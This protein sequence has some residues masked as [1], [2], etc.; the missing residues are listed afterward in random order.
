MTEQ[1]KNTPAYVSSV[2]RAG[3]VLGLCVALSGI[4]GLMIAPAA[5]TP[6]SG[7]GPRDVRTG[8]FQQGLDGY[9]G[10]ADTHIDSADWGTPPQYTVNYGWNEGLALSDDSTPLLRF[11]LSSIPPNSRVYSATLS[12]Y[13]TTETAGHARRVLL[14]EVY[15]DWDEGNQ[16]G[17]PMDAPG[18]HGATGDDAFA[19]YPGEGTNVPW[20]A[21][22]M[23][24]GVDYATD[25]AD[26]VDVDDVGWFDWDVTD[27]VRAWVRGERPNFGVVLRDGTGWEPGNPLLRRF[28]SSQGASDPGLRPVLTIQYDPDTPLADAGPDQENLHWSGTS[29]VLDGSG[30]HDRPGGDDDALAYAWRI[31]TPAYGSDLSGVIGEEEIIEFTPDVPGEWELELTVTNTLGAVATD[32][33][34]VRL[35]SIP[36]SHPR[37]YL[38]PEKLATLRAR[39]TP[40]NVRWTQLVAEAD[41][42]PTRMLH[43]ALVGVV[44]DDPSYRVR[45]IDAALD[46]IAAGADWATAVGKL[47]LVFDWCYDQLTPAERDTFVTFFNDSADSPDFGGVPGWGNYWPR[48]SFSVAAMALATLGDNP[49]AEQ[50]LDHFRYDRFRDH[51]VPAL[52][53]IAAGGGW[54]EGFIYDGIANESLVKALAAWR[55]ATG[56]NLFLASAWFPERFGHLLMRSWPGVAQEWGP[57]YHPYRAVGDSERRRGTMANYGRIMGLILIEQFPTHPLASQLQAY[58]ATPPDDNS[59]SFLYDEEFLWFDPDAP[60][61][62]PTLLTQHE[63]GVGTLIVRSGWPSGA[64]D[65]DTSATYATFQA[66]DYFSYHQHLD[67]NSFTLFKYGDLA[68]DSGVYSGAGLSYHDVNY[69]MRTIAHNTLVVY[70]PSEDFSDTRPYAVSNDG[71]QRS[72]EPASR[73]PQTVEYW[74]Q[75]AQQYDVAD[76]PRFEDTPSYTYALGDATKAYNNPTYNQAML[77]QGLPGNVAKVTRF[78]REFVYLRP[79]AGQSTNRDYLVL[80]DRVGVTDPSFSGENTKLLFHTLNE[81]AVNGTGVTVSP[82]ET[83]YG[84]ADL[85]TADNGEGR[86]FMKLLAPAAH[87]V[88]KLGVCGDKAFWVFGETYDWHWGGGEGPPCDLATDFE[89]VPYGE[90]RIELEPA[91]TDLDHNFLTVLYP[92]SSDTSSMPAT[93]LLEATG[94][95]GAHIAD[96]QLGRIV[97]FSASFDGAPPT[98]PIAYS[99]TPTAP[100]LHVLFDLPPAERYDL[101]AVPSGDRLD[102]MLTPSASGAYVASGMGVLS[103]VLSAGACPG[104]IDGDGQ[105]GLADLATLLA[106]FGTSAGQPGFD[107]AADLDGDGTV[108]LADLSQLLSA[109]GSICI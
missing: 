60:A 84:D 31:V 75:H 7:D 11:D 48:Y 57:P 105:V 9:A 67:Q 72:V 70:N 54:P 55:S 5:A 16:V 49:R 38:T 40:D 73:A 92:T 20:T 58:L 66:G 95:E 52:N 96:D 82:G 46:R 14:F 108:G 103:F 6:A 2:R 34:H 15:R 23:A 85:I 71:G 98:G 36:T 94:M 30:S 24:A 53:K 102:V 41:H 35:L 42:D 62:E 37:I 109:Y 68:L 99:Y 83:L 107:P 26:W 8:V 56:E 100:T 90:W 21:R 19:Y 12:L 76:M 25:P 89:N 78:Q 104:D 79:V 22:G 101:S 59:D 45:A 91:D 1:A 74:E 43:N 51:H 18:K 93:T 97:L 63:A 10:V 44:A 77:S 27:V 13:N 32:R 69:Q 17:S 80:Y 106:A 81:P 86:L 65:T 3:R 50:W 28:V 29:I 39:A 87:N 4:A 61:V 88:R 33:V 47:A 64:A